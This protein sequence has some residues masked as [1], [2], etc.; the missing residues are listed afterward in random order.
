MRPS[1]WHRIVPTQWHAL[2]YGLGSGVL[3]ALASVCLWLG[4]PSHINITGAAPAQLTVIMDRRVQV[5]LVESVATLHA[6]IDA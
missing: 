1:T 4:Q 5:M 3:L 2:A 6:G